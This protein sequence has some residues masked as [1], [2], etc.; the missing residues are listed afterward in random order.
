MVNILIEVIHPAIPLVLRARPTDLVLHCSA[1]FVAT[2]AA[3]PA[4]PR[5]LLLA[6]MCVLNVGLG[7]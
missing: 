7:A 1:D 5:W 2:A 6:G 4:R 3:S